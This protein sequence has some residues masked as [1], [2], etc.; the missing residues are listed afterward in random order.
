LPFGVL[1]YGFTLDSGHDYLLYVLYMVASL[2]GGLLGVYVGY[3]GGLGEE[4]RWKGLAGA[5]IIYVGIVVGAI[6]LTG[7]TSL[8]LPKVQFDSQSTAGVCEGRLLTHFEG[9]WYVLTDK[10]ILAIPDD[11]AGS[12]VRITER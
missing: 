12:E 5:A 9:Y 11:D 1:G 2:L 4:S 7:A 8:S 10:E 3:P 6:C